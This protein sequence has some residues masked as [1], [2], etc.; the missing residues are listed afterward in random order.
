MWWLSEMGV[1]DRRVR[2]HLAPGAAIAEQSLQLTGRPDRHD[3]DLPSL[4]QRGI[5]VAGRLQAVDGARVAFAPDLPETTAAADAR[6]TR[7]LSRIDA[8]AHAVGLDDELEP[9]PPP[10][11]ARTDGAPARLDLAAAGI[12]TVVW[13]TGYHRAYP[14]LHVPVLDDAG[15]IRHVAGTTAAPGLHVMGMRRQT[16]RTSTFL[17]G[18]RHDAALVVDRILA[19]LRAARPEERAA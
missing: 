8:Y 1:L 14:W 7:L 10:T 3:V 9:A 6:L 17:D 2:V 11:A 16:R 13:A 5:A 19:D 4:Q 15:E 18:V 12:R